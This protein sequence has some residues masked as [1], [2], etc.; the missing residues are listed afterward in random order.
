MKKMGFVTLCGIILTATPVV[1]ASG[2]SRTGLNERFD[3]HA[4]LQLKNLIDGQLLLPPVE[5]S[6]ESERGFQEEVL[7]FI[8][9]AQ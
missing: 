3:R 9:T 7:E 8:A 1:A 6:T 4:P 2:Q 5:V